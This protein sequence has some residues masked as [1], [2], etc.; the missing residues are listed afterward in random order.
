MLWGDSFQGGP[1][2][3]PSSESGGREG[4]TARESKNEREKKGTVRYW[5]SPRK[6]GWTCFDKVERICL[7]LVKDPAQ[8][9]VR[10]KQQGFYLNR[11][12]GVRNETAGREDLLVQPST[13]G[14]LL[15]MVAADQLEG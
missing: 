7:P 15:P 3:S 11:P 6:N 13:D 8:C 2:C 14:E 10:M 4:G 12:K 9:A 5:E 1:G